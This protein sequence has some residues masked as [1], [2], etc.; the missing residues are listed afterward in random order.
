VILISLAAA[1][2]LPLLVPV[3]PGWG[4]AVTAGS[5][6]L[7]GSRDFDL[8][9]WI[10]LSGTALNLL[11]LAV[12]FA[13]LL[14][15]SSHADE[16]G[17]DRLERLALDIAA[18]YRLPRP[19]ALLRTNCALAPLTWGHRRPKVLLPLEASTWDD[20]RLLVVLRHEL[21]HVKRCDWLTQAVVMLLRAAFW[22]HPLVWLAIARLR[23][24]SEFACDAYAIADGLPP[25]RY[26]FHLLELARGAARRGSGALPAPGITS[27]STLEARVRRLLDPRTSRAISSHGSTQAAAAAALLAAAFTLAGYQSHP[28]L[29]D[30][31]TVVTESPPKPITLTLMLDGRLVDLSNYVPPDPITSDSIVRGTTIELVSTRR[32]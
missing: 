10:W 12:G 30:P 9:M 32:N 4:G 2:V 22:W 23:R 16:C 17:D 11:S 20:E 18:D 26:S 6:T 14:W 19:V 24:E 3:A 27:S 29:F 28:W 13:R 7:P 8:L 1:A 25:S 31:P 15:V 21:A 5:W